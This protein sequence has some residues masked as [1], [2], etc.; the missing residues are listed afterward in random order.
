M[1]YAEAKVERDSIS[2]MIY[3]ERLQI[4]QLAKQSSNHVNTLDIYITVG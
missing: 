4:L 3:R 2:D 1:T